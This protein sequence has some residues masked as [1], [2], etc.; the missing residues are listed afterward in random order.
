M[1]ATDLVDRL[2]AHRTLGAA[3]R[4]ELAWLVSH[5]SV[6]QMNAGDV[7][8]AKGDDAGRIVRRCCR[9]ASRFPSTAVP[10]RT[11]SWNGGKAT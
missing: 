8:T 7:L 5:G 9:V 11:R 1:T 10:D 4:E 2:A 6:R 3:P